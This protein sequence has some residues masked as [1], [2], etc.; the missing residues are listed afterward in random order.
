MTDESLLRGSF[1]VKDGMVFFHI[2]TERRPF[3]EVKQAIE[4]LRDELNRQ[5]E[6]GHKC[7]YYPHK[8]LI[9]FL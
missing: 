1:A 5:L 7:P 4:L 6:N 3:E 9:Q 8:D 2:D